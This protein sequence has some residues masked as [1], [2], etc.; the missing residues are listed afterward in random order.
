MVLDHAAAV[1]QLHGGGAVWSVARYSVGRAALPL[2][3]GLAG[4]LW[5]VRPPRPSRVLSVVLA[6][7]AAGVLCAGLAF[8]W[9]DALFLY[10]VGLVLS[11]IILAAPALCLVLGVLQVTTFQVL[12]WSYEPGLVVAWISFGV[13][14]GRVGGPVVGLPALDEWDRRAVCPAGRVFAG[15]GRWPLTA[16][17]GHLALLLVL[18]KLWEGVK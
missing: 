18:V 14:L 4:F 17:L 10:L 6:V 15:L 2:F 13:I 5:T 7:L 12:P 3:M 11:P 1:L 9:P 8:P 16:Y